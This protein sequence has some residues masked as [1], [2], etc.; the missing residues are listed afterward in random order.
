[1]RRPDL[2]LLVALLLCRAIATSQQEGVDEMVRVF[3]PTGEGAARPSSVLLPICSTPS[4]SSTQGWKAWLQKACQA[5]RLHETAVKQ[6][7]GI[8]ALDADGAEHT[9]AAGVE[10]RLPTV[11]HV[12][13]HS[14]SRTSTLLL[15][16][17]WTG[18]FLVRMQW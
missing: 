14:I 13:P 12:I 3:F 16:R 10:A 6:C 2:G 4:C 5:R 7:R 17:P 8:I 11:S 15:A 9:T 18:P 1:M